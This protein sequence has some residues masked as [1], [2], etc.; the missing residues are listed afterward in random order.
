MS[1]QNW[2][3][4]TVHHIIYEQS[5]TARNSPWRFILNNISIVSY[6]ESC[7]TSFWEM[8]W[9]ESAIMLYFFKINAVFWSFL[10][11]CVFLL[12]NACNI[13]FSIRQ[14]YNTVVLLSYK[15]TIIN[16]GFFTIHLYFG[17]QYGYFSWVNIKHKTRLRWESSRVHI[18]EENTYTNK[19]RERS[20]PKDWMI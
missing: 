10:I 18:E 3:T 19:G 13:V 11:H 6:S 5:L 4:A 15:K 8:L 7:R 20:Y 14:V 16:V 9:G 12:Y 2:E 1:S 17:Y